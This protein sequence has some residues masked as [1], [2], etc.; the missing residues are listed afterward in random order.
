M[1]TARPEVL[2]DSEFLKKLEQLT[3]LSRRLHQGQNRA[4]RRSRQLGAS[5]EFADYRNYSFGDDLR[6]IDWNVFGR[7]DRLFVKLYEEE[8]DLH[9]HLLVDASAS[10]HWQPEQDAAPLT[11]FDQ[12]RRIAG[13]LAYI[14]LSNLDRVNIHFLHGGQVHDL[15]LVR[16]RSQFH[17]ILSFLREAPAAEGGETSLERSCRT[18]AQR[19]KRRG[20]AFLLS[21]LFD[22]D[23]FAKSLALLQHQRFEVE[24]LQVLEPAELDPG[25]QGDLRLTDAES[26]RH[27]DLTAQPALVEKY[28][29]EIERYCE[30]VRTFCRKRGL[31]YVRLTTD[32]PFEDLVLRFL[33]DERMLR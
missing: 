13:S 5:L 6:K 23:G 16:G 3:L 14:A 9:V 29:V 2:F 12:A 1:V 17:K 19:Q 31:G 24:V 33:R 28:R 15:G 30:E 7:L 18:F 32:Q 26:G 25:L 27:L 21:D 4:E 11:K 8:Q 20:L 22:A 10:M